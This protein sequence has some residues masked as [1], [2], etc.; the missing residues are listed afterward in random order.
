MRVAFSNSL[1]KCRRG[2]LLISGVLMEGEQFHNWL[3]DVGYNLGFGLTDVFEYLKKLDIKNLDGII[4]THPHPDHYWNLKYVFQKF[5]VE[6]FCHSYMDKPKKLINKINSLK[7]DDRVMVPL[8]NFR[9]KNGK[10]LNVALRINE[11]KKTIIF[12]AMII[13]I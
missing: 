11:L 2:R 9:E 7:Y 1:P 13:L 3:L 5:N 8:K 12:I 10:V 4:L 6:T